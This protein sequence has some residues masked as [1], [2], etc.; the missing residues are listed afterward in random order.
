MH[1][2]SDL[3]IQPTYNSFQGNK[4]DIDDLLN[5]KIT[6]HAYKIGD[7][8]YERGNGKCLTMQITVDQ[9]LR[10]VFSGSTHLQQTIEMV[11]KDKFP[12]TTTIIKKNKCHQFT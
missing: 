7:S 12:F 8:K 9:E 4:I 2:F 11:P 10:V 1:S 3:N 6:V 5:K